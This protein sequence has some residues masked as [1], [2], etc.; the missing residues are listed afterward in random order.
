VPLVDPTLVAIA[1]AIATGA[2]A[3]ARRE[4]LA[5]LAN[6]ERDGPVD[7]AMSANAL[8]GRAAVSL[9]NR[10]EAAKHFQRVIDTWKRTAP[11]TTALPDDDAALRA[12]AR[13]LDALGEASFFVAEEKRLAAF[14]KPNPT[15]REIDGAER[16]YRAIV[17]IAP[18]PPPR[19]TA[20]AAARVGD[21]W[22]AYADSHGE[23]PDATSSH[24]RARA[25]YRLCQKLAEKLA[26]EDE[27]TRRCDDWLARDQ[28]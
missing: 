1:D 26:V 11:P 18:M 27:L 20:D 10:R 24:E 19:W 22:A 6:A 14:A 13:S 3:R 7:V 16:A 25:A 12:L 8:A 15:A 2:S 4:V 23:T 28:P 9:G 17:E 21:L 5:I